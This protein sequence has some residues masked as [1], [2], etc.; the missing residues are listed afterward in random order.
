M[1]S[2]AEGGQASPVAANA[3]GFN[4]WKFTVLLMLPMSMYFY[5]L[6]ASSFVYLKIVIKSC[7]HKEVVVMSVE[8]DFEPGFAAQM[9]AELIRFSGKCHYDEIKKKIIY[10]S[11][12]DA[13]NAYLTIQREE[14]ER[15]KWLE[16]EKYK[17]DL[18]RHALMDWVQKY[19]SDF[20]RYWRR[21]HVYIQ[22]AGS[23][24]QNPCDA[25]P[26]IAEP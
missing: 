18:G 1:K 10:H 8:K 22:P 11:L 20:A 4:S 14:M 17:N 3:T 15:H 9:Q 26:K 2:S 13:L 25:Q 12:R 16:S 24:S 23:P 19:S 7:N 5:G 6:G 21:T